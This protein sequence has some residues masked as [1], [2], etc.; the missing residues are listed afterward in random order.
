MGKIMFLVY[1]VLVFCMQFNLL[2]AM[3]TRTYEII[4]GTQ[5]EYKRQWAQVILLLEL[6]LS[7]RERLT[8]LLKYSRPVGTNK[9]KRAFIATRKNDSLTDTERLIREQQFVQQREEKRTFL[10]RRLKDITYSMSK[11]AHAKK[12]SNETIQIGSEKEKDE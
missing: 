4:Y 12:N 8:A 6:S 3:L 9:K 7:P 2:I 11:Y 5:K 1:M 10:K